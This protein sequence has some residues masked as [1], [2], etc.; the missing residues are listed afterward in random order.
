MIKIY[1]NI[2]IHTEFE[3]REIQKPNLWG[4]FKVL[5]NT[6]KWYQTLEL[7]LICD[8]KYSW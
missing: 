5:Q 2:I 8:H 4:T 3:R 1:D 7:S 6:S